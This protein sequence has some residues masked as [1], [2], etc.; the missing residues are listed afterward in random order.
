MEGRRQ[1][2][3]ARRGRPPSLSRRGR[4]LGAGAM[5]LIAGGVFGDR[6]DLLGLGLALVALLFVVLIG[7]YP[8]AVF[9][10]RRYV[11]LAW[12]IERPGDDG[13]I[14]PGRALRLVLELRNHAPRSLGRAT[15]RPIVSPALET[16]PVIV[17]IDAHSDTNA[18]TEVTPRAVGVALLHGASF[19]LTDG[20]GLTSIEA[21]FPSPIALSVVPRLGGPLLAPSAARAA[22]PE[23]PQ[24]TAARLAGQG[25]ELRELRDHRP[26]DP[27]KQIAWKA[28]A[29]RGR[30]T[31]REV[32]R[33]T[34]SAHLVVLDASGWMRDGRPGRAPLDVAVE[35]AARYARTALDAGDQLGLMIV[36]GRVT[37]M[38]PVSDRPGQR[39]FVTEAL[40]GAAGY[41]EDTTELSDAE[42]C[43]T[44][45]RYLL[46]QEGEETRVPPP[47]VDDPLW[48][49]LIAA[50]SGELYELR[51][52]IAAVRASR[53][54]NRAL[55]GRALRPPRA[56]DPAMAE[57]RAF[58][59]DRAISLPPRLERGRGVRGMLAALATLRSGRAPDRLLVLS[60]F[61]GLDASDGALAAELVPAFEEALTRLRRRGSR[62]L[63]VAPLGPGQEAGGYEG[64]N[65]DMS[66][67][68]VDE[69]LSLERAR[70][71]RELA[72][73]AARLGI[74][75]RPCSDAIGFRWPIDRGPRRALRPVA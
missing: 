35:L 15:L 8:A 28:T 60:G 6:P 68:P 14:H 7:Q 71:A 39:R 27:W 22:G 26:G 43:G 5:A 54:R 18:T 38:V 57:L 33:E 23:R 46:M 32:E 72:L 42:L 19:E 73:L 12:R 61:D 21:Y 48:T 24:R 3:S 69:L 67:D 29:R 34:Q 41:D 65:A 75:I 62:F 25:G 37:S 2:D 49:R 13:V 17:Q 52:L 74:A 1:N 56:G 55:G 63:L 50:P 9:I 4:W 36:D 51:R 45:G 58:C 11:E 10:W 53:D 66:I 59:R 64:A 30:L 20:L 44:V 31:V 70:R 47:P 40:S 16:G